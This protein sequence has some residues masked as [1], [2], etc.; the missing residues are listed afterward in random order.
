VTMRF[1][2][3]AQLPP[4]LARFLA[5]QGHQAEHVADLRMANTS[6]SALWRYAL[7]QHTVIVTKDEDF[8]YRGALVSP[9][10]PVV[11]VRLGNCRNVALLKAFKRAL[12]EIERAIAGGDRLVEVV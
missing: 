6:D 10:P 12:P 2:V 9:A 8:S 3:D 7:D 1:L 5:D 11:W 4:A